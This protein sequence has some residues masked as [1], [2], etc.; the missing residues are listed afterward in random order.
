L[1]LIVNRETPQTRFLRKIAK[2]QT[3]EIDDVSTLANPAVVEAPVNG[4]Q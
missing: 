2:D 3:D 4:K 1:L